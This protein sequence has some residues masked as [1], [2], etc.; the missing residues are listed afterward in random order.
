MKCPVKM[1]RQYQGRKSD[2]SYAYLI[3]FDPR[4]SFLGIFKHWDGTVRC[5][6]VD[7]YRC[8]DEEIGFLEILLDLGLS[9]RRI[10]RVVHDLQTTRT[11]ISATDVTRF[12]NGET[13]ELPQYNDGVPYGHTSTISW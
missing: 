4:V 6:F 8:K 2:C 13:D 12:L 9:R 11:S 10:E 5:G 3:E 1:I 7:H